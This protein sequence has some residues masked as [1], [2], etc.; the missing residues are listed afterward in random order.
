[1]VAQR[2]IA[3]ALEIENTDMVDNLREQP[4]VKS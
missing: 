4:L 2:E 3:V 1:V